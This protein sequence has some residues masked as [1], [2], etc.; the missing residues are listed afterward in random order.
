MIYRCVWLNLAACHRNEPSG[1]MHGL[2]RVRSFV[3]DDAHIFC[4][5]EQIQDEVLGFI[6][7]LFT[8]YAILVLTILL[9]NLA[10]RPE[11]RIGSDEIWDKA[12]QALANALDSKGLN[13]ELRQVRVL[14][15][16]LK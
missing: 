12:E 3:Q 8:I 9:I 4:T 1:A 16:V 14:F 13:W 5:E 10:T 11:E 6:D 7:M 2:M 15:M